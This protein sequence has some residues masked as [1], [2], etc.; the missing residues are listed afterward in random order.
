MRIEAK[1]T[2]TKRW[3]SSLRNSTVPSIKS[4][5]PREDHRNASII[6]SPRQTQQRWA[7][8]AVWLWNPTSL[9]WNLCSQCSF[10]GIL[11]SVAAKLGQPFTH[12]SRIPSARNIRSCQ[13]WFKIWNVHLYLTW[14]TRVSRDWSGGWG[15]RGGTEPLL[16]WLE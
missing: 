5:Y 16:S 14:Y 8:F 3:G 2:P 9:L 11:S 6:L 4:L 1:P 7:I 12:K 15:R 13:A 10:W